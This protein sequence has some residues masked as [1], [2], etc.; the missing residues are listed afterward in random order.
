VAETARCASIQQSD[1]ID[2][3]KSVPFLGVHVACLA[4]FRTGISW[5]ALVLCF[6]LYL[7]RM[8]GITAGYHRYFSHRSYKTSRFFQFILAWTGCCAMQKGPLWW[9]AHHRH[10]HQH[11]DEA[12]DVHSPRQ[13]GLWWA[14]IGWI[15]CDRYDATNFH[16]IQDFSKYPELVWLNRYSSIPGLTLAIACFLV[17]GWQGLIW[18]FFISTVLVYHG[19][20]MIN[21]F[22]HVFGTVRYKTRD[23]SRNS[24]ILALVTLG[25]GWHNNHHHYATSARMGFF[26]WEVDL[27]YYALRL[28]GA[29]GVVWELKEPSQRVLNVGDR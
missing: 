9:A 10:H 21:S 8:F 25:E 13:R 17:L 1:G 3:T 7:I 16:A 20:F 29:L 4:A 11:S 5:E 26:W 22:C 6:A 19:T 18:G 27:S 24:L 14:H 28:L 23:T 15:L 2:W 12:E